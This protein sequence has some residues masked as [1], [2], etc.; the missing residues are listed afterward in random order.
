MST[1]TPMNYDGSRWVRVDL[2]LHSPGAYSFK[3]P[4]DLKPEQI[5]KVAQAYVRQLKQ[6]SIEVA[7][8]TDY[9]QIR[10][11]WFLPIRDAALA[12]GIYVYPGVE[13][14]FGGTAGGKRGLHILAIFPYDANID[15]INHTIDK[16]L[17][18]S[19]TEKILSTDGN[20]RELA[21]EK[22]LTLCLPEFRKE[23]GALLIAAHP[24][25]DKGLFNSYSFGEAAK[26]I[27]AIAPDAIENFND[28]DRKR[29]ADT[30]KINLS[31]LNGIPG[32]ENSDNHN[33]TEIGTKTRSD[34]TPRATYLKLS[35]LDDLNAIR[36][37]LRDREILA[38]VGNLPEAEYTRIES[39]EIDGAGFL[40]NLKLA[41]SPELNVLVGGRGTGKSALLEALRY[42]LDLPAY[43]PTEY[44]ENLIAYA[45]GSGGKVS[46]RVHRVM[47]GGSPQQYILERAS[48][49]S[50]RVYRMSGGDPQ[51]VNLPIA[52]V[53][54]EQELPLFFGQKEI[55]DV[56]KSPNLLRRLLDEIIGRTAQRQLI[57]IRKIEAELR[58][59]AHD[60]LERRQRLE[61]REEI[62]KRLVEIE[63]E[64]QL[65]REQGILEK[66][67]RATAL[68][69]DDERLKRTQSVPSTLANEWQ[70]LKEDTAGRLQQILSDLAEAESEQKNLLAEARQSIETLQLEFVNIF[71]QGRQAHIRAQ[72]ALDEILT[73]WQLGRQPLDE[74]IR[75]IKQEFGEHALNPDRLIDMTAE[76]QRL[77]PELERLKRL[78]KEIATRQEE[79]EKLKEKLR[80]AQ[81]KAFKLRKEQAE[82]ITEQLRDR[83]RIQVE[84]RALRM[85]YTESLSAFFSGS[86]ISR[87]SFSQMAHSVP[88][89][90]EL[91]NLAQQGKSV[92]MEKTHISDAY[93]DRLLNFLNERDE[94]WF[95]LELIAAEDNVQIELNLNGN[96][97]RLQKL[98][99]GQ[100]AT[101]MLLIL[102][103]QS[104]RPML[105]DQ[106][107]DDLDNRFI[108]DDVVQ[109]LR[110]QKGLRQLITA[111]HNPNIPVLAHAELVLGLEAESEKMQITKQ[112]GMD[113]HNIQDFVRKV[114]EGGEEAF[115]RR[116]EKYGM[117]I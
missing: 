75:R 61:R 109:M 59:N 10:P 113:N 76:R 67:E 47:E 115:R 89:G 43:S 68:T 71:E 60:I 91:A 55:Y 99:D 35:V 39:V 104:N 25:E 44:R 40:G 85:E 51:V 72:N 110:A 26:L 30:G 77:L 36:L 49:E 7:A 14:S 87:E 108:F 8:I 74:E 83:V 64:E 66:M 80:E 29:L 41:F 23:T 57:E 95:E 45:L 24:K 62:E 63:H 58:R 21:P 112:G 84:H 20:H 19:N 92:L 116:A 27:A 6:Q 106:P 117:E 102:L 4:A 82:K 105:V 50:P 88:D 70:G 15:T 34:G 16:R 9:Q 38:R 48:N 107:E 31:I 103:T 17:D 28:D 73:R 2:H 5:E 22:P 98:S 94:R 12:D 78:E 100:R 53:L 37:A 1:T 52:D 96:W 65:Y 11:E 46:V 54:G 3:F 79:R 114:M 101:A 18:G 97:Q 90:I 81:R 93:A 86:R 69:R 42:V 33:I 56:T 111:T 13:L 32:V